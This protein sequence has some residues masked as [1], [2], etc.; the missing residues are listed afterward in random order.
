LVSRRQW[1]VFRT[2]R[3]QAG[4]SDI[5]GVRPGIDTVAVPLVAT[6]FTENAPAIS[7]RTVAGIQ[8]EPVRSVYI[9]VVPFPNTAAAK[10]AVSTAVAPSRFGPIAAKSCS[11]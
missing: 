6:R 4:A 7:G 2:N 11:T 3:Y 5:L 10:W 9:Y 8:L 1:L